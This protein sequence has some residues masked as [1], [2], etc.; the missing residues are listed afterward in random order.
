MVKQAI[1]PICFL[2]IGEL[3]DLL[4]HDLKEPDN[5][6]KIEN[7]VTDSNVILAYGKINVNKNPKETFSKLATL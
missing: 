4:K 7:P 2:A 3:P 5:F 6:E 1:I